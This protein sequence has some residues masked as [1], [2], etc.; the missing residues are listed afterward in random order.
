MHLCGF[1]IMKNFSSLAIL[2][3]PKDEQTC[4]RLVIADWSNAILSIIISLNPHIQKAAMNLRSKFQQVATQALV[5]QTLD[6]SIF[7]NSTSVV[8]QAGIH[9][10]PELQLMTLRCGAESDRRPRCV[11]PPALGVHVH[12]HSHALILVD[13]KLARASEPALPVP[14]RTSPG[15]PTVQALPR[16][17]SSNSLRTSAW[18]G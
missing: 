16:G 8:G 9:G 4:N 18:W 13:A 11:H 15:G 7:L 1:N 17:I 12:S 3:C 14:E 5:G 10:C 6:T 2:M